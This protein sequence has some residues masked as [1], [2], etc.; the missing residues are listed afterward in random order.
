[1]AVAKAI[2]NGNWSAGST[3]NS[4][5][6]PGN[7]DT[8]YANGFMVTIDQ[9]ATIGGV[10]NPNVASNALV[11]GQ[12]YQIVT[13]GNANFTSYG[14]ANNNVGTIFLATST[15]GGTSGVAKALATLTTLAHAGLSISSGGGFT[16]SG[17]FNVSADMRPGTSIC[18]TVSG[19]ASSTI[20]GDMYP[21]STASTHVIAFNGSGTCSVVGNGSG[22]ASQG[23]TYAISATGSVNLNITGNFTGGSGGSAHAIRFS[24]TGSLNITGNLT[25]G[26]SNGTGCYANNGSSISITGIL[27]GG[28]VSSAYGFSLDFA[29]T[30]VVYGNVYGGAGA[31]CAGTNLNA[32]SGIIEIYGNLYASGV[33]PAIYASFSTSCLYKIHGDV[34]DNASGQTAISCNRCIYGTTPTNAV[35]RKALDGSSTFINFYQDGAASS[36]SGQPASANVRAGTAYGPSGSLLGT[37]QVPAPSSVAYGVPVDNTTGTSV[38]S[39]T[40]LRAELAVELARIDAAISSRNA[41]TPP[42]TAAIASAVH[43]AFAVE[44]ARIANTATVDSVNAALAAQ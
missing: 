5:V 2:A 1:M 31:G 33:S 32:A 4:G 35:H 29:G 10:N 7:G 41:T 14:A 26:N 42:T 40:G 11:I 43:D 24:S 6:L 34:Y 8:V 27:T 17:N 15:G 22:S 37:C 21:S 25:G 44:N 28:S 12:Y 3:W 30:A 18:L 39:P 20:T 16:V 13:V 38:L 19:S 23:S 9:H 36:Q